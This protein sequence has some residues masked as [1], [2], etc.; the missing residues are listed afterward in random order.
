MPTWAAQIIAYVAQI[1]GLVETLNSLLAP[2]AK[3][4]SP[5]AIETIASNAANTVNSPAFGNHAIMD[6]LLA[7]AAA[8]SLIPVPP[9]PISLPTTPP[10][11]YGTDNDAVAAAVW[12]YAL[13]SSGRISGD[14]LDNA[15]NMAVNMGTANVG[16][17]SQK[18]SEFLLTGV[19]WDE[20]GPPSAASG[21]EFNWQLAP[22]WGSLL[23][24]LENTSGWTGWSINDSQQCWVDG[25][26][27][28]GGWQWITRIDDSLYKVIRN[29]I[30]S[31]T[32]SDHAPV[33]PGVAN[34]DI[35]DEVAIEPLLT[36]TDLMDGVYVT[37]TE[38]TTNKP[39]IPYGDQQAWRYLGALA[40][41]N[42]N[43]DVEPWQPLA[44]ANALYT[45]KSM[46]HAAGVVLRTDPSVVGTVTTYRNR[47]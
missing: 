2:T 26:T 30:I 17:P 13:A 12:S 36:I 5:Y 6:E 7:I 3:E 34:I 37:I 33:W 39:E 42:D 21:P 40:F 23:D 43:G 25:G 15:G 10:A 16:L 20:F 1:L 9:D 32:T 18:T 19:W 35:Y 45:P 8:I 29:F 11:G 14:Q 4:H 31:G 27:G 22:L 47:T 44:F 41:V 28:G 38:V 46:A 24:F